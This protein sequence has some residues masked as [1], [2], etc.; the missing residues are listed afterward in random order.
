MITV[1]HVGETIFLATAKGAKANVLRMQ[2]IKHE[3]EEEEGQ[4]EQGA[5][6]DYKYQ[7]KVKQYSHKRK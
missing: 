2:A 1:C 5:E 3:E 7:I 6:E 4:L